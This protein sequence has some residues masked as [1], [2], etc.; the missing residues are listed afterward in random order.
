VAVIYYHLALRY[1]RIFPQDFEIVPLTGSEPEPQPSENNICTTYHIG[2]VGDGGQW[3]KVFLDY[4]FSE[5][6]TAVYAEHGLQR[7]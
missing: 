1:T 7:P 4:M 2:L 6:V 5:K 3:G